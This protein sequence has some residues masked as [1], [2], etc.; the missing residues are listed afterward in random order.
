MI[1]ISL[2]IVHKEQ[3]TKNSGMFYVFF[4]GSHIKNPFSYAINLHTMKY[5]FFLSRSEYRHIIYRYCSVGFTR[6]GDNMCI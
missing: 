3:K 4:A 2:S 5:N 6:F 1:L